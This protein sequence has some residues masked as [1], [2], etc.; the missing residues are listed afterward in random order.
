MLM[1][2]IERP[3]FAGQRWND[4]GPR[5]IDIKTAL[6]E[7]SDFVDYFGS[8]HFIRSHRFSESGILLDISDMKATWGDVLERAYR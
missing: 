4:E 6:A 7:Y 3:S 5:M 1:L 2:L 8:Q